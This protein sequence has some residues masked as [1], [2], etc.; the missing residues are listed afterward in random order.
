MPLAK[1]AENIEILDYIRRYAPE[2]TCS[3]KTASQAPSRFAYAK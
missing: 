3:A 1:L 2:G